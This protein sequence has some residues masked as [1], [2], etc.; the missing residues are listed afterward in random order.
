M[1]GGVDAAGASRVRAFHDALLLAADTS[2]AAAA[3]RDRRAS[4]SSDASWVVECFARPLAAAALRLT[5]V[6]PTSAGADLIAALIAA[7]GPACLPDGDAGAVVAWCLPSGGGAA[8]AAEGAEGVGGVAGVGPPPTGA[9]AA[10]ILTSVIK[11]APALWDD[12][13]ARLQGA[14]AE[15]EGF[16]N[17]NALLAQL[18]RQLAGAG[19]GGGDGAEVS[20]WQR[21]ALDALVAA[22]AGRAE[23]GGAAAD[24]VVAAAAGRGAVLSGRAFPTYIFS[25]R[26]SLV[27]EYSQIS[28]GSRDTT[29]RVPADKRTLRGGPARLTVNSFEVCQWD[30]SSGLRDKAMAL[31]SGG[32]SGTLMHNLTQLISAETSVPAWVLTAAEAWVWPPPLEPAAAAPWAEMVT[33]LFGAHLT[34]LA[35][36]GGGG[37]ADGADSSSGE[38]EEAGSS[39]EEEG[40]SVGQCRLTP[41]RPWADRARCQRLILNYDEPLSSFGFK[42]NSRRYKSEEEEED[43]AGGRHHR[44]LAGTGGTEDHASSAASVSW[45]GVADIARHVID[46]HIVPSFSMSM[47]SYDVESNICPEALLQHL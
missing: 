22:A 33:A 7:H 37:Q 42:L 45:L 47:A 40:S 10:V 14:A 28:E 19:T 31:L 26:F 21:P 46:M 43:V 44:G 25:L 15:A 8:G 11:A 16:A 12:V 6:R 32:T 27:E 18:L 41:V 34:A 5:A 20:R 13:L 38:E 30:D 35:A 9:A 3:K 17:G 4:S 29:V 2:S 24:L 23:G 36:G 39:S 1:S